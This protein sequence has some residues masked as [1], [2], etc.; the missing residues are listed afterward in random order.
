MRFFKVSLILTLSILVLAGIGYTG[1]LICQQFQKPS[2]SP[3][4]AISE[5]TVLVIKVHNPAG[6][7]EE[8]QRSNLIWKD[9]MTFPIFQT[10]RTEVD[11]LDSAIKKNENIRKIVRNYPLLLAVSMTGRSTFGLLILTSVPGGDPEVSITDFIKE[12]FKTKVTILSSPYSSVTLQ[13]VIVKG[14]NEPFY[15]AVKKGVFIGS[16]HADLVKKGI[17]RLSLNISSISGTGFQK[18]ESVTGKKVDA[19]IYINFRYLSSF[20]SKYFLEDLSSKLVRLSLFADWSGLDMIIKRDELL[21]NGYTT[22]GDTTTQFLPLLKEQ[23]PQKIEITRVIPDNIFS[24]IYF[25][26]SDI[27]NFYS[28]LTSY[29]PVQAEIR[30]NYPTCIELENRLKIRLSDYFIPWIGNE[31][32]VISSKNSSSGEKETTYGI[33]R[34]T[35]RTL[36]DSLLKELSVATGKK[37]DSQVYRELPVTTLNI[38]DIIPGTFGSFF[39]RIE[40]S[41]FTFLDNYIIFGNDL[42]SLKR[43][44]DR[45]SEGK[46]LENQKEYHDISENISDKSNIYFYFDTKRSL[47]EIKSILRENLSGPLNPVIDT[48]RKFESLAIQLSN[49]N[50]IFYTRFF[51]RYNPAGTSEGPLQ[52]QSNLDTSIQ[53]RPRIIKPRIHGD[54]A[55]LVTDKSNN[56][57]MLD[58]LGNIRW[59]LHLPG[60]PSGTIHEIYQKNSD[61]AVYLFNTDYFICIIDASGKFLTHFPLRL[62]LKATNA[63]S[64]ISFPGAKDYHI[65]LALSDH[66]L[67]SFNL[68]GKP[69]E[70]WRNPLFNEDITKEVQSL[71]VSHKEFVFI[72]GKN[73]QLLI[74]DQKGNIRI[75]LPKNFRVSA[76][77]MFYLNR[78]N[79]KGLFLT[80]DLAG[81]VVYIQENGTVSEATFNPLSPNHYF[82]YEDVNNDKTS[83]FVFFDKNTLYYYNRL[84]RLLYF[85]SFR[86]EITQP[87]FLIKTP[88]GQ[89]LIGFVD[90]VTNEVFLFGKEGLIQT[91]PGI[92]GNTLFDIGFLTDQKNPELIIGWGKYLRNYRLTQK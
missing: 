32:A 53:E 84:Y 86:R 13:E 58:N 39:G 70:G 30:D 67:H 65:L 55:L 46:S 3:I 72:A 2:E 7:I 33:F 82:L 6:L 43:L 5:N 80:T 31:M 9:L 48:L 83:E 50:G 59:K 54:P 40:G 79:K 44:I 26:L 42:I 57:Y 75:K 73:G 41:S 45:V 78:T 56:L 35:D 8:L 47:G 64:V 62:P 49:R 24:F 91:S 52:W 28:K 22:C 16:F 18:V 87:P 20:L 90:E 23:V 92:H 81:K 85:Y 1:Y 60:K 21:V 63:L 76:N 37:R 71:T 88:N 77:A 27:K 69:E 11:F 74:T 68:N 19:N 10:L 12:I 66:K 17:D 36:A 15:F 89:K 51:I 34:V 4:K 61:S 29:Q 14:N 25:G 38:P